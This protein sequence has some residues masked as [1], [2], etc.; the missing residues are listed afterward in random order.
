[1]SPL[2]P[3]VPPSS[4]EPDVLRWPLVG[5][6]LRW[7]RLRTATQIVL[8]LVAVVVVVHGLFGPGLAPGIWAGV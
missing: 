1:M 8:L 4:V 6:L 2:L 7:R 5:P 3:Q